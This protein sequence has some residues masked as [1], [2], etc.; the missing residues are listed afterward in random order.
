[1]SV[2]S[3]AISD[4]VPASTVARTE[5]AVDAAQ[6]Y[7]VGN[8]GDLLLPPLMEVVDNIVSEEEE[9][10][11]EDPMGADDDDDDDD[12]IMQPVDSNADRESNS[13]LAIEERLD[14]ALR[15]VNH[16]N[17]DNLA[18]TLA[19]DAFHDSRGRGHTAPD[20]FHAWAKADS[21]CLLRKQ[22]K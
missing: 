9:D 14:R 8:E 7:Q 4:V 5:T 13:L 21:T 2:L 12:A 19:G 11:L 3:Q 20:P 22:N 6:K 16:F 15:E 10:E 18:S 1:M 17:V